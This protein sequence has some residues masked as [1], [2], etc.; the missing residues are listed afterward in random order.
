MKFLRHQN[1]CNSLRP[2]VA[3]LSPKRFVNRVADLSTY[4]ESILQELH[5][6]S[7]HH[8]DEQSD[9]V[10]LPFREELFWHQLP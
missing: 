9:I 8:M 7:P 10:I 2:S 1:S 6:T 3:T 5:G 4:L